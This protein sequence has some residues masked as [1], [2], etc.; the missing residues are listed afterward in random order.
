M[1]LAICENRAMNQLYAARVKNELLAQREYLDIHPPT[2][3]SIFRP[4]WIRFYESP[5]VLQE[6]ISD[7]KLVFRVLRPQNRVRRAGLE[8]GHPAR[9]LGCGQGPH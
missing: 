3:Y 2:V 7:Q 8:G 4:L 1:S 9:L 5:F 6:I